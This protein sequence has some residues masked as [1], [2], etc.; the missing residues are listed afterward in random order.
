MQFVSNVCNSCGLS[1]FTKLL[2][3]KKYGCETRPL[4]SVPR[5][6][7]IITV[8]HIILITLRNS[9]THEIASCGSFA[10]KNLFWSYFTTMMVNVN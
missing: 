6:R 4:R 3:V 10:I 9:K 2:H 1:Q 5:S 7:L 8:I